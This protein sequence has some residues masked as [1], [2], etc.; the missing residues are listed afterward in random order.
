[1]PGGL[2]QYQVLYIPF[3]TKV[4]AQSL[5]NSLNERIAPYQRIAYM[6]WVGGSHGGYRVILEA[7]D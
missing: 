1:M 5:E 4:S 6:E 3:D 7:R 2:E